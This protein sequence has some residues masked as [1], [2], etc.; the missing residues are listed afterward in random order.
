LFLPRPRRVASDALMRMARSKGSPDDVTIV[1]VDMQLEEEQPCAAAGAAASAQQQAPPL[2]GCPAGQ[3]AAQGACCFMQA[4]AAAMAAV[5]AGS[6]DVAAAAA[7]ASAAACCTFISAAQ[8]CE[9]QANSPFSSC[10]PLPPSPFGPASLFSPL[11]STPSPCCAAALSAAQA[12]DTEQQHTACLQG[13][14]C[15]MEAS[16]DAQAAAA[17]GLHQG[18]AAAAAA[19]GNAAAAA[20]AAGQLAAAVQQAISECS[21]CCE[22]RAN[23]SESAPVLPVQPCQ[24][25]GQAGGAPSARHGR[26]RS[27]EALD[28]IAWQQAALGCSAGGGILGA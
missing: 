20:A 16:A 10:S 7:A 2:A 12:A 26:G 3:A 6:G 4:A 23:R 19:A 21:S 8:A 5:S 27:C 14:R 18:A 11:F 28:C 9:Q 1:V 15:S 17:A 25:R 13:G 22:V 24:G